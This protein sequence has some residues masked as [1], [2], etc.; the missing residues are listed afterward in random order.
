MSDVKTNY[1]DL[2]SLLRADCIDIRLTARNN[3]SLLVNEYFNRLSN[4]IADESRTED[5]INRIAG[6]KAEEY[7]YNCLADI[8]K[9]L[10]GI[11]CY[12]LLPAAAE[13]ISA[14][15]RGHNDFAAE[16]A[17]NILQNIKDL[18]QKLI[19][20]KRTIDQNDQKTS[21]RNQAADEPLPENY[22]VLYGTQPLKKVLALLENEENT[23]KMK[24]LAIDDAP[25]IIQTISSILGANYKVYG[26][27]NP[28][29]LEKFLSQITPELFLLDYQM[30][31]ISGFDLIPIIRSFDEHKET[32]IIFLTSSGTVDHVSAA[33]ALGAADFIVKPFQGNI[34]RE[35]VAKHIV[36]KKLF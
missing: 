34:L 23:R 18:Y 20:A 33:F 31:E 30:P 15:K 27:T 24:I 1:F 25:V 8:K 5:T 22:S 11:G 19:A 3:T 6:L 36:R 12:K 2:P 16:C 13:I 32:P 21:D 29:L 28:M 7:D 26:M 9:T 10:E 17:K 14:G 4:Y 35:K